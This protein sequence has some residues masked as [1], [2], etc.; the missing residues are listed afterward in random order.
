M[1]AFDAAKKIDRAAVYLAPQLLAAAGVLKGRTCSACSL[2]APECGSAAATM[3]RSASNQAHVDNKPSHRP[4]LAMHPQWL[5]EVR[6]AAEPVT[7]A[8]SLVLDKKM[9]V[10]TASVWRAPGAASIDTHSGRV[11]FFTGGEENQ[12]R[13]CSA[14]LEAQ[15]V[16]V[17]AA[18]DAEGIEVAAHRRGESLNDRL[19]AVLISVSGSDDALLPAALVR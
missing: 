14:W 8:L 15:L 19:S 1:R 2:R 9:D 17:I 18:V 6:Q 13:Y 3:R 16:V 11:Y 12:R 5:L 10:N 4:G 7:L